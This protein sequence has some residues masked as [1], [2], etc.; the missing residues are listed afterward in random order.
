[1]FTKNNKY[2]IVQ[3]NGVDSSRLVETR[4]GNI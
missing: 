2:I 4:F 3:F 1:M